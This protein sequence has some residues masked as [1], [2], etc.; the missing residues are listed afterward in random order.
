MSF[1]SQHAAGMVRRCGPAVAGAVLLVLTAC[2]FQPIHGERSAASSAGL[3]HFDIGL[4]ADRAGQMMRNELLQQMQPR[5]AVQA[6]RFE[7]SMSLS[8]TLTDLAIRKDEVAT[9][10]NLTL[11]ARYSVL[12]RADGSLVLSGQARSVNSYNILTSDFATL[13]ARADARE[14]A[15]RQLARDIK[16]RLAVWLVQTGGRPVTR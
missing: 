10:A 7:L 12:N 14:R 8:E 4:I 9:R 15:V 1:I 3:A 6:P 5:G 2:G 16:E 11:T 13:S